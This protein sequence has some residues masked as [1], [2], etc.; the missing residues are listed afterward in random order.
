MKPYTFWS[1]VTSKW[2]DI[3]KDIVLIKKNALNIIMI[4]EWENRWPTKWFK[5]GLFNHNGFICWRSTC[6]LCIQDPV[7]LPEKHLPKWT[8]RWK[9]LGRMDIIPNVHFPER[10]LARMYIWPNGHFPENLFSRMDTC[11]NVHLMLAIIIPDDKTGLFCWASLVNIRFISI[12]F[13]STAVY[14]TFL[15]SSS[16]TPL[17]K[18]LA[19]IIKLIPG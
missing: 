7:H 8:F 14:C 12:R 1:N 16:S 19:N 15:H 13:S 9:T 5:P 18:K 4:S 3:K 17:E 11:Q 6:V 2:K 10:T